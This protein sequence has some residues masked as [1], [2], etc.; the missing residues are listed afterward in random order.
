MG[1]SCEISRVLGDIYIHLGYVKPLIFWSFK[2][3]IHI[4]I[5]SISFAL[6]Y[7]V[8]LQVLENDMKSLFHKVF[9]S[10][11]VTRSERN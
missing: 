6:S 2:I 7:T 10:V 4:N 1:S 8:I 5:T 3:Q 11:C 9:F